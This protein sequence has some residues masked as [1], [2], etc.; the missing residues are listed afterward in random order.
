MSENKKIE[1]KLLSLSQE[2]RQA[3]DWNWIFLFLLGS[4]CASQAQM[5]S[6]L[7][8]GQYQEAR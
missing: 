3:E 4:T 1:A 7:V 6:D 8:I 2:M 5:E